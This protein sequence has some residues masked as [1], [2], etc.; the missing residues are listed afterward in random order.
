MDAVFEA[1][2]EAI[3]VLQDVMDMTAKDPTLYHVYGGDAMIR[4][5]GKAVITEFN[6]W[7]STDWDGGSSTTLIDTNTIGPVT[8]E[9]KDAVAFY[10]DFIAEMY[11]DLFS[12]ILGLESEKSGVESS[13]FC[14]GRVREVVLIPQDCDDGSSPAC[15]TTHEASIRAG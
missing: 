3:P 4:T 7:P 13:T 5:N 11:A 15:S 14:D 6:D 1:L 12:I 8:G 2:V 10:E 9:G